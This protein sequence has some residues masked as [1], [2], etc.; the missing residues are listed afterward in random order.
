MT[1]AEDNPLWVLYT[2]LRVLG[3]KYAVLVEHPQY[4]AYIDAPRG[5]IRYRPMRGPAFRLDF[6]DSDEPFWA[7]AD[8]EAEIA[9]MI[10]NAGLAEVPE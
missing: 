9:A 2:K 4:D 1:V 8:D 6:I 3:F 7:R 5:R 10:V